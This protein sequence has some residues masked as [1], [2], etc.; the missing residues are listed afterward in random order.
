M[1]PVST[2]LLVLL[3]LLLLLPTLSLLVSM[4]LISSADAVAITVGV[5]SQVWAPEEEVLSRAVRR[6]L[7]TGRVIPPSV[8]RET[9]HAVPRSVEALA[10]LAD[11]CVRINNVN[12][13]VGVDAGV[14]VAVGPLADNGG[15]CHRR[16]EEEEQQHQQQCQGGGLA[17]ASPSE[18]ELEAP[19]AGGASELTAATSAAKG[20][21]A[22]DEA[23]AGA[24]EEEEAEVPL[25]VLATPGETWDSFRRTFSQEPSY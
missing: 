25:P 2:P 1:L 7:Q 15:G 21:E 17:A 14:A 22:G 20:I 9:I 19:G 3:L 18:L 10:P 13:N 12:V 23:A 5:F 6:G 4:P 16:A 11:Y 8:L 24:V